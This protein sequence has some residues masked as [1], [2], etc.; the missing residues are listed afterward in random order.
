VCSSTEEACHRAG[1]NK[2]TAYRWLK[3]EF[4]R[5]ELITQRNAIIERALDGLK[6]SICKAAETLVQLL[7]S[8]KE[9]IRARAAEDIIEFAQRALEQEQ[10][11]ARITAIERK[12]EEYEI[13]ERQ[14]RSA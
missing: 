6:A 11:A 9:A 2:T 8:N 10:L 5:Q 12:V 14:I 13:D 4:F 7:D 3:D 1:I